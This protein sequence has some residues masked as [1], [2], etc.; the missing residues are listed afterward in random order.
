[1]S[2]GRGGSRR[3][4]V[5][6]SD[7]RP[8]VSQKTVWATR[9]SAVAVVAAL[10]LA[11]STLVAEAQTGSSGGT[12][13]SDVGVTSSTIRIA[14]VADVD[15]PFEPGLFQGVRVAVQAFAGYVNQ[16]GGIAGRRLAVDFIDSHLSDNDARNAVI[17]ACS[18]DFAL[19]GTAALFL[20]N[21]DDM[22]A[23][24]DQSGAATG[25][26]DIPVVATELAEQCSPVSFPVNPPALDCATRERASPDLSRQRRD[27][28]LPQSD[29][30][31][32]APRDHALRRR[33]QV[34]R[35]QPVGLGPGRRGGRRDL[36]QRDRDLGVGPPAGL[37]VDRRTD[38]EQ[39]L[40][41]RAEHRAVQQQRRP[42]PR[43][44]AARPERPERRLGLLLELL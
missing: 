33:P 30:A 21:V 37:H 14:V 39:G 1:M 9:A 5:L 3:T 17:K 22:V 24:K 31:Q 4:I 36:G 6:G 20:N 28:A 13:S 19:V 41:L 8:L 15:N 12:Q 43:G 18:Q 26:P 25:L 32:D 44:L 34:G 7:E 10:S 27:G 38:E 40:Q 16:T 29:D 42:P 35:D 11:A 2:R 23:C